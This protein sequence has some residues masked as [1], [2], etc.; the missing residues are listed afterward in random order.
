MTH[1][2][3]TNVQVSVIAS[4]NKSQ[5]PTEYLEALYLPQNLLRHS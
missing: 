3:K 4:T 1:A 2:L 5:K